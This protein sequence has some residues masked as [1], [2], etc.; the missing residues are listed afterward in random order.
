[1]LNTIRN[2]YFSGRMKMA[3]MIAANYDLILLLPRF[4]I[5]MG[6]GDSTVKE[7]CRDHGIDINFFLMVCNIYSFDDYRPDNDELSQIDNRLVVKH[8]QASH[9]YYINERLPHMQRF[10]EQMTASIEKTTG[11]VLRKYFADYYLE[12]QNHVNRE[13]RKL[14][15]MLHEMDKNHS[16]SRS[17][18][19]HFLSK[20]HDDIKDKLSDLTKII[21]KYIPGEH[22][23][24]ELTQMVFDILQLTRDLERHT[25]VEEVLLSPNEDYDLSDREH[26][27]LKLVAQGLS[28][29]EIAAKLNIAVNTVNT[30]R[31]NITKK[32]GIK[33]VAGLAVYTM[34]KSK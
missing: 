23:S 18:I 21:Y 31:K 4:G 22:L 34:L 13:E 24:D 19:E 28:S 10:L 15:A 7:V 12:V 1:M 25:V 26:D 27:V 32:T 8:L 14:K 11:N 16:V 3:D 6:F 2:S 17:T 9:H 20:G 5:P 30:H 33:S 29:K